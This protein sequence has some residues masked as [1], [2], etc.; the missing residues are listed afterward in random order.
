VTA[1]PDTRGDNAGGDW[2]WVLAGAALILV[3]TGLGWLL[4]LDL[5]F[6]LGLLAMYL[7]LE[8]LGWLRAMLYRFTEQ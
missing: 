5:R 2:R 3:G 6:L 1:D 7:A 8:G 4:G